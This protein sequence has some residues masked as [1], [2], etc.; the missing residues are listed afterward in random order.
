MHSL[1]E[2]HLSDTCRTNRRF[3]SGVYLV[4]SLD[5][6]VTLLRVERAIGDVRLVAIDPGDRRPVPLRISLGGQHPHLVRRQVQHRQVG[7]AAG[8]PCR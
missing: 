1:S 8:L 3:S 6:P 5:G 7:L 2:A 4:F